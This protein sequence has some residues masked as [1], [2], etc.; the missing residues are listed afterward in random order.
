VLIKKAKE[1]KPVAVDQTQIFAKTF[2]ADIVAEQDNDQ[3]ETRSGSCG[4]DRTGSPAHS[5][6]LK[7]SKESARCCAN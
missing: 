7:L 5:K 2:I 4:D 1:R 3:R 6:E